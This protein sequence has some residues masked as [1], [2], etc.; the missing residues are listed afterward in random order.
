MLSRLNRYWRSMFTG[1]GEAN[2]SPAA[3]APQR[4][5]ATGND[6]RGWAEQAAAHLARDEREDA[7][8]C[9]EIALA[10]AADCVA[11]RLG[12]ARMLRESGETAAALEHVRLALRAAPDDATVHF[13]SALVHNRSGDTQ[14]AL[15]AY[16]RA[17]ELDPAS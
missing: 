12:L 16:Q 17:L 15:A 13:E 6:G 2:V 3:V 14:G 10:H 11:A 5:I 1:R 4:A 9:Y 7:R 8:D